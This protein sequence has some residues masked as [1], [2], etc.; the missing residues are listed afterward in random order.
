[1]RPPGTLIPPNRALSCPSLSW[2]DCKVPSRPADVSH[3]R[4]PSK[5]LGHDPNLKANPSLDPLS[6]PLLPHLQ[7]AP[8][9]FASAW[10]EGLEHLGTVSD[11]GRGSALES[12]SQAGCVVTLVTLVAHRMVRHVVVLKKAHL[13]CCLVVIGGRMEDRF[14]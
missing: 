8:G 12:R 11:G 5:V 1:V 9:V 3:L 4:F 14:G 2:E 13:C 10:A 6:W 7:L